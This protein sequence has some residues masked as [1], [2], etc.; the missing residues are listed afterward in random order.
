M[1]QDDIEVR[2]WSGDL[3]P[4]EATIRKILTAE[5]LQP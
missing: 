5:G 1:K 4:D 3:A 2:K